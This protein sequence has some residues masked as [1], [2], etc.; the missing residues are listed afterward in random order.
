MVFVGIGMNSCATKKVTIRSDDGAVASLVSFADL[1]KEQKNLGKVPVTVNVEEITGSAIKIS[2]DGHL[3]SYWFIPDATGEET[4]L[5]ALLTPKE[6]S[7]DQSN[8]P[9]VFNQV[10]RL[11]L[12]AYRELGRQRFAEAKQLAEK[13]SELAP[14]AAF[15]QVIIGMSSAKLGQKENARSAFLKAKS[16]DPTDTNIAGAMTQMGVAE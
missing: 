5:T 12:S 16:L 14:Y 4:T 15:P 9:A 2:K 8:S 3:P 6:T 11:T 10:L 7:K 1:S 13:A